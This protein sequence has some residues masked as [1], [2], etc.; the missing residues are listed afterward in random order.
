[1]KMDDLVTALRALRD[2]TEITVGRY[3]VESHRT[4]FYLRVDGVDILRK[5]EESYYIDD[6]VFNY[7]ELEK[8]MLIR[9]A[10][11]MNW[12]RMLTF[13]PKDKLLLVA[14]SKDGGKT[15]LHALGYRRDGYFDTE[16]NHIPFE[17]A[18][19]WVEVI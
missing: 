14:Y 3:K 6:E 19:A 13:A 9:N 8:H 15:E 16:L 12:C 2:G 10:E 7:E 17:K 5:I 11:C 4:D 18:L 1:M